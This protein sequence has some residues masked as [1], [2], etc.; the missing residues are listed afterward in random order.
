MVDPTPFPLP[1]PALV[2]RGV[3]AGYAQ[4]AVLD[5][6]DLRVPQGALTAIVGPNGAG[7]STLVKAVLGLLPHGGQI[8]VL[9]QPRDAALPRVAYV[10]QRAAVDWDF[11]ARVRDVV[12]MGLFRQ[13]GLLGRLSPA[14]RARIDTAIAR[15]GLTDLAARQIGALSGGQQQR[16]FIARALVQDPALF[17]LDEPFAGVDAATEATILA[18][19]RDLVAA[20]RTVIAIHH[21]IETVRSH[22][23]RAVLLNGRV[24]AEGPVAGVLD[25][26][27]VARAYA[28][29]LAV[30]A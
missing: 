28:P 16:T 30:P 25:S 13:T 8:T 4:G 24:I 9:G 26:A 10:P 29:R 7:K 3:T 21:D 2:L 17:I 14:L 6:V 23:D 5:G 15:V 20:G 19:L 27:T 22:F 18:L 1:E 11:P 12:A